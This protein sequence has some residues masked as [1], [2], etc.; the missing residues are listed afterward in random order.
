MGELRIDRL[1]RVAGNGRVAAQRQHVRD[2]FA[3]HPVEDL[4]RAVRG[5]RAGE[6]G[7]RLDV[8]V[9]FDP[10]HEFERLLAGAHAISHR[11]PI[12]RVSGEC[13][14]RAL[15]HVDLGLVTRGHELERDRRPFALEQVRDT[16]RFANS[17]KAYLA[18]GEQARLPG[19]RPGRLCRRADE[20]K[21]AGFL[22]CFYLRRRESPTR[23]VTRWESRYSS[24][25]RTGRRLA[26]MRSRS[27]ATV[28]EPF[29]AMISFASSTAD[30]YAPLVNA[31][32]LLTRTMSPRWTSARTISSSAPLCCIAS[33]REGGVN[34][35]AASNRSSSACGRLSS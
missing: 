12:G 6:V 5:V 29:A 2:S 34:G 25:A 22:S 3:L 20:R 17:I 26:P 15:Q 31:T 21:P 19:R 23:R 1:K 9:T 10:R 7:H 28:T 4:P 30:S 33:G 27:C 8:V 32:S 18:E 16:H 13:R 14:D 11:D 24:S 35:C